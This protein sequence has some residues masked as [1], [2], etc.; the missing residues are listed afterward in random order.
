MVAY[1]LPAYVKR[2][3][4]IPTPSATGLAFVT[5]ASSIVL[6]TGS[7]LATDPKASAG[8]DPQSAPPLVP[9]QTS[10]SDTGLPTDSG[11]TPST[12]DPAASPSTVAVSSSSKPIA[13]STVIATCV[14]AFV[15]VA[16]LIVFSL[17]VYRRYSRSL[18]K[19]ARR[20]GPLNHRNKQ[21][22]EHQRRSHRETWNKLED[23]NGDDR[24]EGSYQTRETKNPAQTEVT[25]MEKLTMF[26]KSASIRTAYTH[27]S[28]DPTEFS[29]PS[30]YAE[31]DPNLAASLK[32]GSSGSQ[33]QLKNTDSGQ[34]SWSES[35]VNSVHSH[36][37]SSV[38][39]ARNIAIP[40]PPPTVSHAHK[41]ESAEV[42]HYPEG[43]SA[44]VVDPFE[45]EE[46]G[47]RKSFH[48]PFFSAQDYVPS[49]RQRSNSTSTMRSRSFS[50]TRSRANSTATHAT[51]STITP[52]T[53]N[54]GKD[55][56][57]YSNPKVHATTIDP[58][59]DLDTT[60]PAPA[61]ISHTATSS[62]SS[63][64]KEE[65]ERALKTLIAVLNL[66]EE[67]VR[68]RLRIASM[69]P[70]I[71]STASSNYDSDVANDFPLP[72]SA[73]TMKDFRGGGSLKSLR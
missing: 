52:A 35:K 50:R 20:R 62:T 33:P 57:Q 17:Y 24:W 25:P 27:K 14:G 11:A 44:E 42:V 37:S 46:V 26:K 39:L 22:S 32:V 63:M 64:D 3:D 72:P 5:T 53:A 56:M 10:T 12:I 73:P 69:Q 28:T 2:Q 58:F 43:Q 45:D 48:N 60:L 6:P 9:I 61:F 23:N 38:S 7:G 54:K 40:T 13:L 65:R 59:D 18:E 68:D 15:G 30:S 16:A 47:S 21:A 8:N 49:R 34:V 51:Q 29:F 70:S 1:G 71:V 36:V 66:P 67:E 31:F 4:P 41:W 19:S 55:R